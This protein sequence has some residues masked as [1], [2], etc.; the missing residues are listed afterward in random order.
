[1]AKSL[2]FVLG[3]ARGGKSRYAEQLALASGK[4][5]LF[6]ATA[7]A[8][9]AE[10]AQRI[11][12]HQAERPATWHTLEAPMNV[13]AA[14]RAANP[15][16]VVVIDCLTL[17]ASNVLLAHSADDEPGPEAEQA[18]LDETTALLAA[19]QAGEAAWIVISNE[20]GMGLVPPY[21]LGRAYRDALGRAN[22]MVAEAAD[23]VVLLVA[24]LPWTLKG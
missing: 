4:S 5:V 19:Y 8:G 14:I 2:T 12:R 1:M 10:M 24:G 11:A 13:G 6:V 15:A 9:D 7:E 21:P 16:G 17:L 18:I 23:K 20:V 3:G 22:Q